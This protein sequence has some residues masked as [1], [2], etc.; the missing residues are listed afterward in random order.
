MVVRPN[1]HVHYREKV[2]LVLDAGL[3]LGNSQKE[4]VQN[5]SGKHRS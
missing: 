3:P 1:E 4:L 2:R 5:L